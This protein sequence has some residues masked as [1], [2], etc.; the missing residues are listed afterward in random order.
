[1]CFFLNVVCKGRTEVIFFEAAR[2]QRC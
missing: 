2:R 1:M